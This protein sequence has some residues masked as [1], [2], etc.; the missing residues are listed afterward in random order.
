[1]LIAYLDNSQT[2]SDTAYID[3]S[4]VECGCTDP[5][6]INYNPLAIVDD[7][8]CIYPIPVVNAPNIFTPNG[9]GS[10]DL[11]FFTTIYTVQ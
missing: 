11:F 9:D 5:L 4:V 6:A 7:G 1:M 2:C 10:N 8:S 3:I